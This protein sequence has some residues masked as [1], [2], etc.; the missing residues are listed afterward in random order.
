MEE[1]EKFEDFVNKINSV[2]GNIS[3]EIIQ[4]RQLLNVKVEEYTK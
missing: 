1:Q 3:K 2:I 4:L